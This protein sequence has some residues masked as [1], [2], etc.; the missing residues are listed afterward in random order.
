MTCARRPLQSR[1]GRS[2]L[3]VV[4]LA[5]ILL[6]LAGSATA[7]PA[8]ESKAK[9]D[10]QRQIGEWKALLESPDPE[11]RSFGATSLL[12]NGSGPA[13]NALYEALRG[14]NPDATRVSIMKAVGI[15]R[16]ARFLSE[17]LRLLDDPSKAV[18]QAAGSALAL[19][20]GRKAVEQILKFLSDDTSP[21]RSRVMV[22]DALADMRS[23]EAIPV[24]IG[25][26]EEKGASL[27]HAACVGLKKITKMPLSPERK[28]WTAWWDA[29]RLKTREEI[30]EDV[31]ARQDERIALLERSVEELLIERLAARKK[32]HNHKELLD[33]LKSEFAG[34]RRFAV[35]EMAK[36]KLEALAPEIVRLL[37]DPEHSV[38]AAAAKG[39]GEMGAAKS[40]DALI[41]ALGDPEDVVRAAATR[42]LGD[43]RAKAAVKEIAMLLGNPAV[44][45]AAAEALGKIGDRSAVPNLAGLLIVPNGHTEARCAAAS[46]LG[47]LGDRQA[48]E[49]LIKALEDDKV[50]WF[51]VDAIGVLG[52]IDPKKPLTEAVPHLVRVLL[53]DAKPDIREAAAV[54]LGKLRVDDALAALAKGLDD[55]ESRVRDQALKAFER[56]AGT[57]AEVYIRHVTAAKRD[58]AY[59]RVALLS[60]VAAKRFAKAGPEAALTFRREQAEALRLGQDWPTAKAAYEAMLKDIPGDAGLYRGLA[61]VLEALGDNGPALLG[62]YASARKYAPKQKGE[63]WA[64]SRRL[65]DRMLQKKTYDEA[66]KAIAALRKEDPSLGTP[67]VS[68][69]LLEARREALSAGKKADPEAAK[70]RI[71]KL[72]AILAKNPKNRKAFVTVLTS[73][74]KPAVVPLA[75]HALSHKDETVQLTAIEALEKITG[76]GFGLEAKHTAEQREAAIAKW[77]A[78]WGEQKKTAPK[79]SSEKPGG[80]A[81]RPV[82]PAK[83]K[84]VAAVP[85]PKKEAPKTP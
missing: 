37:K 61:T 39:I 84:R 7:Q 65:V 31:I 70:E 52:A 26:L 57:R 42:S 59:V 24:L 45:K 54:A 30:L 63:W 4:L 51:A 81:K 41:E 17:I 60:G 28:I 64:G 5:A 56:I 11:K 29:N 34:V 23:I 20:K 19:M 1:R 38:R 3:L 50:R 53:G 55:G 43:L 80:E 76:Q 73:I 32:N 47:L 27:R 9:V 33:A 67:E 15:R 68:A 71:R 6:P 72:M 25:L 82:P 85:S 69:K 58:K 44:A 46:A 48:I 35:Q 22:C 78:W 66:L 62:L 2:G 10:R 16:D 14:K 36:T 12:L 18:A 79:T 49:A 8:G 40:V 74:G 13:L 77:R 21:T 75:Q 83:E